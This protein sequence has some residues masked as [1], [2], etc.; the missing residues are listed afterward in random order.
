MA[1]GT[2]RV[3]MHGCWQSALQH[4]I[5]A[6]SQPPA[7][8]P[9]PV[10]VAH[11]RSKSRAGPLQRS[12]MLAWLRRVVT[13]G[14]AAEEPSPARCGRGSGRGRGLAGGAQGPP[15]R[16]WRRPHW[17]LL[18]ASAPFLCS[19]SQPQLAPAQ[20]AQYGLRFRGR[21]QA[22]RGEPAFV[23]ANAASAHP[24]ERGAEGEGQWNVLPAGLWRV[25]AAAEGGH[26]GF[27][28]MVLTLYR[29]LDRCPGGGSCLIVWQSV[30]TR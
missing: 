28:G 11:S 18:T 16:A 22:G 5:R 20:C 1:A 8:A 24:P 14:P 26:A 23:H 6:T 17:P 30:R 10:C 13:S 2:G 19:G 7:T 25:N 21:H 29:H 3:D 15:C 27:W 4:R 9:R 12:L